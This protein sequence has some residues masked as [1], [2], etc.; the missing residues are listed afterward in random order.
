MYVGGENV[1]GNRLKEIGNAHWSTPS[2]NATNEYG[3]TGLPGG[4]IYDSFTNLGIS[5]TFWS[6]TLYDFQDA[7][8]VQMNYNYGGI[9]RYTYQTSYGVSVRCVKD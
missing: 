7:Y 9:T 2:T 3:F 6:N 8:A 1:G 5:G 4:Q